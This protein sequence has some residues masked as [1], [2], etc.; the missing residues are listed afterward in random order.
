MTSVSSHYFVLKY[1]FTSKAKPIPLPMG[2]I[3]E[4]GIPMPA[5]GF[6]FVLV[7]LVALLHWVNAFPPFWGLRVEK[8]HSKI[9]SF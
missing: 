2:E 3:S 1:L 6:V 9:S 8:A 7:G 5:C 4:R